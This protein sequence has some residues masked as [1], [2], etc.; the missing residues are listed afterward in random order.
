[1]WDGPWE[2]EPP[3]AQPAAKPGPTEDE[4]DWTGEVAP[5]RW[6]RPETARGKVIL[7][8]SVAVVLLVSLIGCFIG[9]LRLSDLYALNPFGLPL[10]R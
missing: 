9:V 8:V 2:D 4:P 1:M 7:V 5:G 3:P 6:Y 10:L